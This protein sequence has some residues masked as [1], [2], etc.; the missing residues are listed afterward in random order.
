MAPATTVGVGGPSPG[1]GSGA[2]FHAEELGDCCAT[3][4]SDMRGDGGQ[5]V[6]ADERSLSPS[7]FGR[8]RVVRV[9]SGRAAMDVGLLASAR[10]YLAA[11]ASEAHGDRL[12]FW[13][14]TGTTRWR[15]SDGFR[16]DLAATQ[17]CRPFAHREP[18]DAQP[19][20][21]EWGRAPVGIVSYRLQQERPLLPAQVAGDSGENRG[22]RRG[23]GGPL[24]VALF[25]VKFPRHW[26]AE[27][28]AALVTEVRGHGLLRGVG[29]GATWPQAGRSCRSSRQCRLRRCHVCAAASRSP[30][31]ACRTGAWRPCSGRTSRGTRAG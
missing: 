22:G 11:A 4:V 7:A 8:E 6:C 16:G 29:P 5:T 10:G 30:R 24:R 9:P 17:V 1:S 27:R 19:A 15:L 3:A 14:E 26:R 2:G 31:R 13:G 18:V 21:R 23:R 12:R 25:H 20:E 28:L